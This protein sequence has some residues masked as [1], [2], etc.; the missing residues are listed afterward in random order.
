[1]QVP[2]CGRE[3]S[4]RDAHILH[5]N[6]SQ[7]FLQSREGQVQRCFFAYNVLVNSI[8]LVVFVN[9]LCRP[10]STSAAVARDGDAGSGV[11][12]PA[13]ASHDLNFD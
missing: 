5:G 11:D 9:S 10:Y 13:L 12:A 7:P 6:Q 4:F 8:S 3:A 1:M 2:Q